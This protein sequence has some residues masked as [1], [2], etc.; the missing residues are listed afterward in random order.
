M[1]KTVIDCGSQRFHQYQQIGHSLNEH[2]IGSRHMTLLKPG[3]GLGQTQKCDG[4]ICI[5]CI[6][7]HVSL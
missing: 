3:P 5:I 1:K 7:Y 6:Q 4:V 2:K